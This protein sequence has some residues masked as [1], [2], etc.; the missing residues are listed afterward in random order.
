MNLEY[1]RSPIEQDLKAFMGEA[2]NEVNRQAGYFISEKLP[3]LNARSS[4]EQIRVADK[5]ESCF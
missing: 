4:A 3:G 1:C 5:E 2:G